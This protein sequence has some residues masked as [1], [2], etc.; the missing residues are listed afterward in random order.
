MPFS[1][2]GIVPDIVFNPHGFPSRMTIG[3]IVESMAGKVAALEGKYQSTTPF[4]DYPRKLVP[5]NRWIDQGGYNGWTRRGRRYMTEDELKEYKTESPVD[6]FGK[7]LLRKGYQYY[8]CEALYSGIYGVEMKAHVFLGIIYYQRLRHMV[9]DK[10]QCR[11]VGPIDHLTRQPLKGRK[12]GGGVR[13]GEMERDTLLGHG[14][15]FMLQ[16]RLIHNSDGHA[17]FVCPKCGSILSPCL[18]VTR[19]RSVGGYK[20]VPSC[21]VCDVPCRAAVLPY[22]FRYISNELAAMNIAIKLQL[23]ECDEDVVIDTSQPL[24][25]GTA[26]EAFPALIEED[27]G[28]ETADATAQ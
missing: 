9:S 4:V 15:A 10:W 20:S 12:R 24:N 26:M 11:S 13:L 28:N 27:E 1:P 2:S 18:D 6:F 22:V 3:M 17:T 8:G 21:R 7:S 23:T 5:E 14:A 19:A 16:D 25:V